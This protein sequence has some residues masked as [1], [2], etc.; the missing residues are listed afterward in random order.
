[1][2]LQ[3]QNILVH[4]AR[5]KPSHF[6]PVVEVSTNVAAD[7]LTTCGITNSVN[8]SL[9]LSRALAMVCMNQISHGVLTDLLSAD[10][11]N[12]DI[13]SLANYL[14]ADEELP[15][16]LNFTEA[17]AYVCRAARQG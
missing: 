2:I 16:E 17:T 12:F 13:Q 6:D 3:M 4:N 14:G 1:M 9:M 11:N 15:A 10:G 7:Q 5:D 8:T